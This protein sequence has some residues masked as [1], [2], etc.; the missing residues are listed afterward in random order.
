[1]ARTLKIRQVKSGI[2]YPLDQRET[3]RALGLRHHQDEVEKADHPSIR[4]M[5]SKVAHLV[6]VEEGDGDG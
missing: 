2:G 1:V 5:I 6:V 4:G 3:L